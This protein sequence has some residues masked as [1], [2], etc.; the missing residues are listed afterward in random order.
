MPGTAGDQ[1]KL[2]Q[3]VQSERSFPATL[4]SFKEEVARAG[5]G[6]LNIHN[7]AGVLS[8]RGF[9]VNPVVILD[10]C[11]GKYSAQILSKDE[12][13]PISVFMPC[14]ISIYQTADG[15]VFI[16]RMNT[17]AF[18]TMLP[19]EVAEVMSASDEEVVKIISKTAR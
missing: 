3:V 19:P 8:E 7:M 13:R 17:G 10:I 16:A 1:P 12:Y 4:K 9:T 2:V 18:A 11:S 14:R 6:I 5:W 15:K